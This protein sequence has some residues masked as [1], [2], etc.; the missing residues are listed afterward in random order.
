MIGYSLTFMGL[1][2]KIE[3]CKQ[4]GSASHVCGL[5]LWFSNVL[6]GILQDVNSLGGIMEVVHQ[7]QANTSF[8]EPF[9]CIAYFGGIFY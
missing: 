5:L 6:L 7:I 3:G 1:E 8:V 4:I 9:L 2:W